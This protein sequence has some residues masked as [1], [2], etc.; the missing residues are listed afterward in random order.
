MP[1]PPPPPPPPMGSSGPP[2]I[3]KPPKNSNDRDALLKSIQKGAKLK[4]AVTNDKSAPMIAGASKNSTSARNNSSNNSIS[5]NMSSN[6]VVSPMKNF[7]SIQMELKKQLANVNEN[8]NRGPPPPA[9]NRNGSAVLNTPRQPFLHK[10]NAPNGVHLSQ[11]AP[12]SNSN[13]MINSSTLHRKA[14]SNANLSTLQINEDNRNGFQHNK[15]VVNHGKPNLAPKP[16]VMNGKPSNLHPRNGKPV[17]RAHSL[18]TPRSPSPQS[19]EDIPASKFGTVRHMSSVISQSLANASVQ[20]SRSRPAL[21][22]RPSAPPP[23]IPTQPPPPPPAP[24]HQPPPSQPHPPPPPKLGAVK[25]PSHAPPPPPPVAS[26]PQAPSHAPPPP[27]HKTQT[28]RPPAVPP[29]S[30][31][32][33]PPPPPPRHSSMRDAA[34]VTMTISLDE[35]YKNMFKPPNQFPQPPPYRNV[36]KIYNCKPGPIINSGYVV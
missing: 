14:K 28:I 12:N 22:G 17:S 30:N 16:P 11:L 36:I 1:A 27:P 31:N 4:K 26:I 15:L 8:R 6:N 29:M 19:P 2:P 13:M 34:S 32:L 24:F 25:H 9:P 18:K 3:F 23:S 33:N 7:G 5:P 21:N 35:K 10:E 20:N